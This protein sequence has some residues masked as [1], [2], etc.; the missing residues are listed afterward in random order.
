MRVK[1]GQAVLSSL[2]RESELDDGRKHSLG[3]LR[4]AVR[5][6]HAGAQQDAQQPPSQ[7]D[8]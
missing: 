4:Y 6:A 5:A 7:P 3:A 1:F 8:F 2:C